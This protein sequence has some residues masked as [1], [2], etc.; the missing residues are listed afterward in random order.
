MKQIHINDIVVN[1][2]LSLR[3]NTPLDDRLVW[4]G[5][6]SLYVYEETPEECPLYG[7]AY[8]GM[9]IIMLDT[10]G[11]EKKSYLMFLY[12][13][14][15]Y[16]PGMGG[17]VTPENYLNYWRQDSIDYEKILRFVSGHGTID[18]DNEL[19]FT[20]QHINTCGEL[21][22][23]SCHSVPRT[24]NG[25]LRFYESWQWTSGPSGTSIIEEI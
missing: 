21:K 10:V 9:I 14:S 1:N 12:D 22:T 18:T 7:Q 6:D 17:T 15:P 5:F 20:Y 19:Q 2:G 16:I 24:E 8:Q 4:E 11:D 23:G 13:A 25:K 3:G